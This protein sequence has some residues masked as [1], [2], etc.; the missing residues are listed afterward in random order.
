MPLHRGYARA[1]VVASEREYGRRELVVLSDGAVFDEAA[2]IRFTN[3]SG[4]RIHQGLHLKRGS[5]IFQ[6]RMHALKPSG[7]RHAGAGRG[8]CGGWRAAKERRQLVPWAQEPER[9]GVPAPHH[10]GGPG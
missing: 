3:K 1:S 10:G 9:I 2:G 5:R 4:I 7:R 8:G 6:V